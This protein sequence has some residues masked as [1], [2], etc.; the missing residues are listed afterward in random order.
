MNVLVPERSAAQTG[1]RHLIA[2][3]AVEGLL[4]Q[5]G[6]S[7]VHIEGPSEVWRL[8]RWQSG[9]PEDLGALLHHLWHDPPDEL[10]GGLGVERVR[11]RLA[12]ELAAATGQTPQAW[13]E[14]LNAAL[15]PKP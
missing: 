2:R 6:T 4:R 1:L 12:S 9:R 11:A 5:L 7:E 15:D 14:R 13:A 10:S 8:E 3:D